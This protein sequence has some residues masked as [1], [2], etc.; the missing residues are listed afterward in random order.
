MAR[1]YPNGTDCQGIV[2]SDKKP[3]Y[4]Q[5]LILKELSELFPHLIPLNQLTKQAYILSSLTL[6]IHH[7]LPKQSKFPVYLSLKEKHSA[8]K[9]IASSNFEQVHEFRFSES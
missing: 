5:L 6:V 4:A 3:L 8:I 1:I 7:L 2:F 9:I